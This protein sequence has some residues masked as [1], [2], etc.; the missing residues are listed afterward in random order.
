MLQQQIRPMEPV[1]RDQPF[2]SQDHLFEVKWDGVRMLAFCSRHGVRLQN[3]RLNDRTVQYPEL[4]SL[5]G[6]LE[7]HEAILDGEVIAFRNNRQSFRSVMDR[8]VCRTAERAIHLSKHNPVSYMVF[9]VLYSDGKPLMSLPLT[10]RKHVLGDLLKRAGPPVY[11]VD[12][13][14]GSG[15]TLWQAT[16]EQALEGIVAKQKSSPYVPGKKSP[17][18][19]KVKHWRQQLCAL[20]GYAQG[21]AGSLSLLAGA[22]VGS[23]FMYIGRVSSGLKASDRDHLLPALKQMSTNVSPFSNK[24]EMRAVT[25]VK[26]SL[27]FLA[28][29]MEWTEDLK[30]RSPVLKGFTRDR[31]QDCV[32]L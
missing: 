15:K 27:T 8:D 16:E 19:V 7:G 4:Q 9:D 20:G 13:Y 5:L 17:H 22:Y 14:E 32:L 29:F 11:L 12:M 2:D 30:M 6:V 31:P 10:H 18:W 1:P 28:E 24:V 26:P 23:A 25:W 3:R 21:R